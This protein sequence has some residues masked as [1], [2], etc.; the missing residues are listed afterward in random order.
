MVSIT[1]EIDA[2]FRV[3]TWEDFVNGEAVTLQFTKQGERDFFEA[4]Q[5]RSLRYI[6]TL[7][8]FARPALE[9]GADVGTP[10]VGQSLSTEPLC[11]EGTRKKMMLITPSNATKVLFPLMV[12]E[13]G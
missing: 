5:E 10:V 3:G 9:G 6:S 2:Q 4:L 1:K 8:E 13:E 11:F 12:G 7:S